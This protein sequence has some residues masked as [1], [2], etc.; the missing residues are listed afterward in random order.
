MPINICELHEDTTS[1][2]GIHVFQLHIS[3]TAPYTAQA[4][5]A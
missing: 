5:I 3:T 1:R 4:A 2:A